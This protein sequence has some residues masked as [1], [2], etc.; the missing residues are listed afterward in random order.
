VP[1]S[2]VFFYICCCFYFFF[3]FVFFVFFPKFIFFFFLQT[4]TSQG[5]R[6]A[7]KSSMHTHPTAGVKWPND[8]LLDGL[9]VSGALVDLDATSGC[10][11]IGIGVNLGPRRRSGGALAGVAIGI[12]DVRAPGVVR[13]HLLAAILAEF[14]RLAALPA[15]AVRALYETCGVL[16]GR[17][18]R[19]HHRTR[20]ESDPRDYDAVARGIAADGRL[21][22]ERVGSGERVLLSAEEVSVRQA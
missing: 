12:E 10:A 8:V 22:V 15:A 17:T 20:E 1:G 3:C 14:E 13:E 9:K 2:V 16:T 18:V 21:I 4:D 7:S 5:C 6:S 11:V 19:V